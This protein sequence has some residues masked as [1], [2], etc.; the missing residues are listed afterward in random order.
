MTSLVPSDSTR[1]QL[2]EACQRYEAA[3]PGSPAEKY[4]TEERAITRG[5]LASFRLGYVAD[6]V[7]GHEDYQGR[8]AIPYLTAS[9]ITSMRFRSLV[10]GGPKYLSLEGEEAR[11][12]NPLALSEPGN[13][14]CVTEGEL[15]AITADMCGLP[16][17][18]IPGSSMW[19]PYFSRALRWYAQVFILRDS[20][21]KV[22]PDGTRAGGKFASLVAKTTK[23]ALVIPMPEGHDVNSFYVAE[24]P[25][26]LR[27]RIGL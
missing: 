18:G 1:A 4:L 17:I 12:F 25:D 26:A 20:D 19:K 2:E 3:M 9:G 21:D 27:K 10:D 5:A 11:I 7:A 22:L 23:S 6:P 24:G 8:I 13:F 15:D 16:A 14:I